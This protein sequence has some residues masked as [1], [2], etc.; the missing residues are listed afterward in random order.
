MIN[1][2]FKQKFGAVCDAKGPIF[3][4]S[5]IP[6]PS[7]MRRKMEQRKI[8]IDTARKKFF[9]LYNR[10]NP[11][12]PQHYIVDLGSTQFAQ[13]MILSIQVQFVNLNEIGFPMENQTSKIH[14]FEAL[15]EDEFISQMRRYKTKKVDDKPKFIRNLMVSLDKQWLTEQR[16]ANRK[17]ARKQSVDEEN[18][19]NDAK[20]N[21]SN[22][23]NE[24]SGDSAVNI[25]NEENETG[26]NIDNEQ[27]GDVEEQDIV[28]ND[29]EEPDIDLEVLNCVSQDTEINDKSDE[30]EEE[31]NEDEN[32]DDDDED[33]QMKEKEK[34]QDME[35]KDKQQRKDHEEH[36]EKNE[37]IELIQ[38]VKDTL[39]ISK[40]YKKKLAEDLGK[41]TEETDWD[42]FVELARN[43]NHEQEEEEEAQQEQDV[44]DKPPSQS[45]GP[46]Y[47][48]QYNPFEPK[49]WRLLKYK[50]YKGEVIRKYLPRKTAENVRR[51]T[52]QCMRQNQ[53]QQNVWKFDNDKVFKEW[54]P[55]NRKIEEI[56]EKR[57]NYASEKDRPSDIK[58]KVLKAKMEK[59]KEL[60]DQ[61]DPFFCSQVACDQ[62]M[63]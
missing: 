21:T 26:S 40:E 52:V 17:K 29:I 6:A 19:D 54:E 32:E 27:S 33:S 11:A 41:V 18:K 58:R 28:I 13:A 15:S 44:I 43:T 8:E 16:A 22:K 4:K 24:K 47:L 10:Q 61:F 37:E 45:E 56:Q 31:Q 60:Q 53:A 46:P 7:T 42:L 25:D 1:I 34:E 12:C 39:N 30:E 57:A 38:T 35:M 36:E 3:G 9:E 55:L 5:V 48:K 49:N 63:N 59:L 23:E 62:G 51:H 14:T 2:L 20:E 50:N